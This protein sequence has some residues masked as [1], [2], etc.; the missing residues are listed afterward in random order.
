MKDC[1]TTIS[2][3]LGPWYQ[4]VNALV[5]E[6]NMATTAEMIKS[7]LGEPDTIEIVPDEERISDTSGKLD[8]SY[9]DTYY[10]YADP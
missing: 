9:P 3:P 8:C 5:A 2:G 7:I 4:K 6:A 1:P 10:E